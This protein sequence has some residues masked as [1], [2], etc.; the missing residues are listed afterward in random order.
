MTE[1]EKLTPSLLEAQSQGGDTA[2]TGFDFQTNLLICKIPF[3]LSF[4]GFDSLIREAVADFESKFFSP[5][6][7]L[8]R[9]AVEAKNHFMAPTEFWEEIDRFMEI[10]EGSPGVFGHFTLCC[11]GISDT[12]KPIIIGLRRIRDPQPFYDPSSYIVEN[13]YMNFVNR[14]RKLKKDEKV[15]K[16]LY[17]KVLIEP[18]WNMNNDEGTSAGM[19]RSQMERHLSQ[20]GEVPSKEFANIHQALLALLRSNKAHPITRKQIEDTIN[21]AISEK[22]R[23]LPAPIVIS[24]EVEPLT[25]KNVSFQF[26]WESYFGGISRNYPSA[27]KWNEGMVPQLYETA[28]WIKTNR[29]SRHIVLKGNRRISSA[30]A[31][32]KVFSAVA[33]F[34]VDMEYRGEIWSTNQYANVDTPGYEFFESY[35][36]GKGDTLIV[37]IGIMKDNLATE[38]EKF[39]KDNDLTDYPIL[40]LHS[41]QPILSAKQANIA[42]GEMKNIIT[43]VVS[44][45]GAK[46]INFFYAGPTHLALFFGHRANA[47]P[48]IQCFEWIAPNEYVATCLIR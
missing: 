2:E 45:C 36:S 46:R 21:S 3:W 16:F 35:L 31:F 29:N 39:T 33:G 22:F 37:T 38:V 47:L 18:I 32:G 23:P 6:N 17:E 34:S 5:S 27:Q 11:C 8:I 25:E 7:G 24:T 4:E 48:P 14:V 19:F 9:E 1:A 41:L 30:V 43:R 13:S 20:Y 44:A 15:A 28:E 42:V 26:E 10:D 40:H 12:L